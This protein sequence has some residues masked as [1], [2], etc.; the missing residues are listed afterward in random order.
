LG[1]VQHF[2]RYAEAVLQQA[3]PPA[4]G[5]VVDLGSNDGS[6][7]KALKR[8]GMKPVGVDPATDIATEAT[9]AGI[10]TYPDFFTE[11]LTGKIREQHGAAS[12]ITMNNAFANIDNLHEIL[13]GVRTLLAN[14]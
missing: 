4:G 12:L 7:L 2:D 1:L 10:P 5:L 6:L 3:A 11:A 13:G 8:R 14:T 9:A